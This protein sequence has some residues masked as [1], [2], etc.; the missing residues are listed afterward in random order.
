V[1]VETPTHRFNVKLEPSATLAT[2]QRIRQRIA[3]GEPVLHLA[4]GE[5]GLPVMDSVQA[6]LAQAAPQNAYGPVVG[7]PAARAAAAGYF[8]R[9]RLPTVP[10]QVV[11][12]PGSK[13][14]LWGVISMLPGDLLL[15][16]PSWVSYAAQAALAGKRVWDLPIAAAA[17]GAPDPDALEQTIQRARSEGARPGIL[18]LTIPDNPTGTAAS[19]DLV[20]RVAEIAQANDLAIISDE[21]YRDLAHDPDAMRSPAEF[22]PE[23]TY[24]TSGLSKSMALGGW[25]IGFVRLPDGPIG[26]EA[27]AAL[28]ALA[29]EVWSSLAAPMQSVAAHV[30]AEPPEVVAHIARSRRLHRLIVTAAYE[31]AIRAGVVCRPPTAAFY[32]YP[33]LEPMR[34]QL[35]AA[36]VDGSQSLGELLLERF[37]IGV[38]AGAVFGDDPASLRVR[39][40]TSLLYGATD[41][42]RRQ[43]LASEDPVALAPVQAALDRFESALTSLADP[44]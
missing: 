13:S 41:E 6:V 25:R 40:A 12:G 35:E 44:A 16:R 11:F 22:A 18:L 15:P 33:D 3:A 38:L 29:S 39:V 19:P 36:G 28:S 32:I 14:L 30:L 2:D 7:S 20:A 34:P 23:R 26:R 10:E 5:A 24:I 9:R 17:G 8:E 43:T 4:F 37:D 31:R 42:E 1:S 27:Q 21:I